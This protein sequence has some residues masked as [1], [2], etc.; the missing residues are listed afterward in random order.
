MTTRFLG[1]T[2]IRAT[3]D[4]M[5]AGN[6]LVNLPPSVKPQSS[7]ACVPPSVRRTMPRLFAGSYCT[8]LKYLPVP[9]TR[10]YLPSSSGAAKPVGMVRRTALRSRYSA[11]SAP[12]SRTDTLPPLRSSQPWAYMLVRV[13]TN[14]TI[15]G[16][17]RMSFIVIRFLYLVITS[18]GTLK[19]FATFKMVSIQRP[20]AAAMW[21]VGPASLHLSQNSLAPQVKRVRILVSPKVKIGPSSFTPSAAT[22]LKRPSRRLRC[23]RCSEFPRSWRG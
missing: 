10:K 16:E 20:D 18:T 6:S 19:I 3:C 1:S 13:R 21:C 5:C 2:F 8:F 23:Q 7:S 14:S 11:S 15:S 9:V 17:V 12:S 22:N 4:I